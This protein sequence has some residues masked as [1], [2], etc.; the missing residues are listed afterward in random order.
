MPLG[1]SLNLLYSGRLQ[2]PD[3]HELSVLGLGHWQASKL[4]DAAHQRFSRSA[5][6]TI[7]PPRIPAARIA[8][9]VLQNPLE[10]VIYDPP[11]VVKLSY[12]P[13]RMPEGLSTRNQEGPLDLLDTLGEKIPILRII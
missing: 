2:H 13:I 12:K 9:L 7:V 1:K 6:R 3:T 11:A 5:K 8:L 4:A 10:G